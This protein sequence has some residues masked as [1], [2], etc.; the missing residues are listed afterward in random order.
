MKTKLTIKV[1]FMNSW[2]SAHENVWK[3]LFQRQNI[4][5]KNFDFVLEYSSSTVVTW[6]PI[7][8]N[9]WS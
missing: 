6:R 9:S 4:P 2:H 8:Q 3:I 5:K 7:D 1:E